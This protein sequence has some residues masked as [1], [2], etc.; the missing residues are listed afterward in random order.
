[1]NTIFSNEQIKKVIEFHGHQCPGLA[2]GIRASELCLKELGHNSESPLVAICETDMCGVDAIQF[3]TG[4]SVGKGNL[5]LKDH[6]KMAFTFFRRKDEKGFRA[7]LNHSFM[8]EQ[9][10]EM[11][12]LMG[13]VAEGTASETEKKECKE[14][15]EECENSYLDADLNELFLIEKPQVS[16]PR[17]AKI[18][19]SLTCEDCG[20]VH[21]ESRS[22]RFAGQTLCIPC[23]KKV[24]QKI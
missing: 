9:R 12:R 5:I 13:I 4:C 8:T 6:G 21:M 10:K 20:E 18:L 15:R 24:E 3:L 23:F 14:I 7:L 1:M 11:S 19:Q 16:V 2:I 22:R 17:P